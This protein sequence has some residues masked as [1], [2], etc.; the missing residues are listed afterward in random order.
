[1]RLAGNLLLAVLVLA[2]LAIAATYWRAGQREAAARAAY[3]PL[4][5]ILDVG[6][7]QVHA[8]VTGAGPDIVLIH[9][10]GGSL[11]D[12][13]FDLAARLSDRYRVIA[14]DRPGHGHT[15]AADT[16]GR[17][18]D[19][20]RQQAALLQAA[21]RQLD[22]ARPLVVGHSFGGSVA[23]AWALEQPGDTAG[24]VL[25]AG[26]T[27]PWPGTLNA[28]YRINSSLLG[29]A[30]VV[31][32]I[33]AWVPLPY[34]RQVL[35]GIFAPQPMPESYPAEFGLPMALRRGLLRAN[36]RQVNGLRP[37]VVEMSG[38][39]P[40]L[41]IPVELL[42]GDAD[43]IVP[44]HV[45]SG[46]LSALLPDAVLTVLPGVGHMPHHAMPDHVTAAVDRVAERAGLR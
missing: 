27:M 39:Y 31:P 35:A 30:L 1:M 32:A 26:A 9:G 19:A 25:L 4:G 12:F 34:A 33:T 11:R 7:V 43:E 2:A 36:A 3:P 38:D 20:P 13:T 23:L 14:F 28:S 40:G 21:A 5:Q 41:E 15:D 10:A 18:F 44:L 46:P 42:H 22:I 37:H 17:R 16:A 24:V 6:G 29:G 8:H 45:H